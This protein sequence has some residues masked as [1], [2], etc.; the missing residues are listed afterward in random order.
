MDCSPPGSSVHGDSPGKNTGV[1]C[2]D[3]LQGIF[4]TE[5]SNPGLPHCR[6]IL[7]HLSHHGRLSF[8]NILGCPFL[9]LFWP[10]LHPSILFLICIH[11]LQTPHCFYLLSLH[12]IVKALSFPVI[13]SGSLAGKEGCIQLSFHLEQLC[14]FF[15]NRNEIM[16]IV[17]HLDSETLF[18]L[19]I[20]GGK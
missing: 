5:G 13:L 2:H 14:F 6:W 17:F 3:L 16:L 7:Y 20:L 4:P 19:V 15:L 11:L 18:I 12:F 1:G 9:A 10:H 8:P